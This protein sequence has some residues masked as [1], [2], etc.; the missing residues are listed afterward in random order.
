MITQ[1]ADVNQM[2]IQNLAIVFG[3]NLFGQTR[4]V[5]QLSRAVIAASDIPY[6][7][8]VNHF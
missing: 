6:Q 3:P 2:S 8:L 7:I 4:I 5:G 1:H